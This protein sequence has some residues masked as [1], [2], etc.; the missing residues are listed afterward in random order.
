VNRLISACRLVTFYFI[1]IQTFNREFILPKC[2]VNTSLAEFIKR[3][4]FEE[5]ESFS[6]NSSLS[7]AP[8]VRTQPTTLGVSNGKWEWAHWAKSLLAAKHQFS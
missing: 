1:E 5:I 4:S 6:S 3:G 2:L 7:H 8:Q